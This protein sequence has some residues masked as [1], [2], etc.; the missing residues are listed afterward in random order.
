MLDALKNIRNFTDNY[1]LI[2]GFKQDKSKSALDRNN[3]KFSLLIS[4]LIECFSKEDLKLGL[5]INKNKRNI[6]KVINYFSDFI[7]VGDSLVDGF[8]Q[9]N[10]F[11]N[12]NIFIEKLAY[13]AFI[14]WKTQKFLK[15]LPLNGN[16]LMLE[17]LINIKKCVKKEIELNK[18]PKIMDQDELFNFIQS[19]NSDF[20]L[21]F[22]LIS[23]F[24]QD[25]TSQLIYKFLEHYVF[26]DTILDDMS[27][28]FH[29]YKKKN[30]N[31]LTLE[32]KVKQPN[33]LYEHYADLI[34]AIVDNGIYDSMI[35]NIR[36]HCDAIKRLLGYSN[37]RL[38]NYLKFLM[39]GCNEGV[40][41]F[42][43]NGYFI[44]QLSDKKKHQNIC[45]FLFKPYPWA[46]I[47]YEEVFLSE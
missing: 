34:Q 3:S 1:S 23:P 13:F 31:L 32:L 43:D 28:L 12:Y 10:N 17:A 6:I 46:I 37:N 40:N 41:I 42:Q 39:E 20:F 5:D 33:S 2:G 25:S 26:I 27:D 44:E 38:L 30:I 16:K 8:F 36:K 45:N 22:K 4:D 18:F 9:E 21:Y 19:R 14:P 11:E 7:T 29:D 15:K 35:F 47:S 24:L